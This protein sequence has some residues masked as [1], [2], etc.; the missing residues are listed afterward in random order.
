MG[1]AGSVEAGIDLVRN[2]YITVNGLTIY[3]P[4]FVANLFDLVSIKAASL[5]LILRN[6]LLRNKKFFIQKPG[7]LK[8]SYQLKGYSR[9]RP[10]SFLEVNY[11]L[12][13]GMLIRVPDHKEISTTVSFRNMN[14]PYYFP[15]SFFNRTYRIKP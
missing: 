9:A 14:I 1:F 5:G 12:M 13:E 10:P 4:E 6:F 3:N 8:N 7:L 2:G 11:N 15:R